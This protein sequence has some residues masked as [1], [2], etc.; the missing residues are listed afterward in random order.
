MRPFSVFFMCLFLVVPT[1]MV[2]AAH[3]QGGVS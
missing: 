2:P 3:A 1:F